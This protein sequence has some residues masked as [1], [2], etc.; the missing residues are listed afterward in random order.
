MPSGPQP[1]YAVESRASRERY[2]AA[3]HL[4]LMRASSMRLPP[5]LPEHN[6]LVQNQGEWRAAWW[7][8]ATLADAERARVMLAGRGLK[9]EVVE[10]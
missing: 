1:V 9:V 10:L 8:F 5:P 2:A 7:P 6:E 3:S 4:A